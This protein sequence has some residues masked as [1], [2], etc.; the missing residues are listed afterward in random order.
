MKVFIQAEGE[1]HSH[2]ISAGDSNTAILPTVTF[3]WPV[4]LALHSALVFQL[5]RH[6]NDL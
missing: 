3:I 6:D 4:L 5:S 2:F 1:A